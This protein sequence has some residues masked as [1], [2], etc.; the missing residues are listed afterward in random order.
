MSFSHVKSLHGY[1]FLREFL[2]SF[3]SFCTGT[4]LLQQTRSASLAPSRY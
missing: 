2:M 3:V 4:V 1:D